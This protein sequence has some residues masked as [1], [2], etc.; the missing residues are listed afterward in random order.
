VCDSSLQDSHTHTHTERE[1]E[2]ER[3]RAAAGS[4][5]DD[6]FTTLDLGFQG[7]EMSGLSALRGGQP[8]RELGFDA[9]EVENSEFMVKCLGFKAYASEV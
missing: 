2:R 4:A 3:E 5:A 9:S 6:P 7:L 1:R 8:D